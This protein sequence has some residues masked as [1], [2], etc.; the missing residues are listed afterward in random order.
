MNDGGSM[1]MMGD[2]EMLRQLLSQYRYLLLF[3]CVLL[4]T[5]PVTHSTSC[6]VRVCLPRCPAFDCWFTKLRNTAL[7]RVQRRVSF[8]L[9]QNLLK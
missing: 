7:A 9:R 4:K 8:S 1:R 2:G 6:L 5:S 3:V